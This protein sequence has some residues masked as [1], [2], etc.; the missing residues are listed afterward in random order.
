MPKHLPRLVALVVIV[1]AV[2]AAPAAAYPQWQLSTGAARCNQCHYAPAGGGLLTSYGRDAAG[3]DLAT[4]GGNGA[5]L[6]GLSTLPPW[7]ALG[8]DFRGAFV[9]QGV[10]DPGGPTI[11]AF[12]MQADVEGRL[13]LP[14]TGLSLS[15]TLGLRGQVRDPD[16]LVPAQNY[17]PVSTSELISREHYLMYQPEAIGSYVRLGRFFAPFGLRFAEHTLYIRRDLGFDQLRETYN[18]SAGVVEPG[19]ELHVAIFAPDFV[20]EIGSDE[21][22]ASAYYE[23]RLAD[24]AAAFAL[25]GRVASAP[26]VTRFIGGAVGKAWVEPARTL[27]FAEVDGVNLLFDDP[28]VGTRRQVVAAAGF[29]VMPAPWLMGTIIGEHNQIDVALPDAWTALNA[30]VNW[31]P[32][33]HV[34][35]QAVGRLQ[36]P[37][38]GD[39]AKTFLFQ[40]HYFL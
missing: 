38:G 16:V 13:A 4:F 22:G 7:L 12:P 33:A 32:Y 1:L 19:W 37:T 11:A 8:G 10:Q 39:T 24:G 20:R 25:Q 36:H 31:F 2:R 5:F 40:V 18:V 28:A 29:T 26:G 3:E 35:L 15:G 30:L 27:V 34:E 6:H 23:R 21:S 9:A 17:Q 14:G